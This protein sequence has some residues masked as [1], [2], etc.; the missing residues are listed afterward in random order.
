MGDIFEDI[1]HAVSDAWDD[2]GDIGQSVVTGGFSDI[3]KGDAPFHSVNQTLYDKGVIGSDA[4]GVADILTGAGSSFATG[5]LSDLASGIQGWH[6]TGDFWT[7]LDRT[8][9]PG[10]SIDYSFRSLGDMLPEEWKPYYGT[11]GTT[12]GGIVGSYIPVIG[13]A[14][15][16]AI[17]SGIGSKMAGGME[18]KDYKGDF[19]KAGTAYVAGKAAEFVASGFNAQGE[20]VNELGLTESEQAYMDSVSNQGILTQTTGAPVEYTPSGINYYP[21]GQAPA[22]TPAIGSEQLDSF[23]IYKGLVNTGDPSSLTN[24]TLNDA[25]ELVA[26]PTY[27]LDQNAQ[28]FKPSM[29]FI[30]TSAPLP[31][32]MPMEKTGILGKITAENLANQEPWYKYDNIKKVLDTLGK[33]Y[34][35]VAP[36]GGADTTGGISWMDTSAVPIEEQVSNIRQNM[37]GGMS[38]AAKAKILPEFEFGQPEQPSM[39][40]T[41]LRRMREEAL[42]S[43]TNK[44]LTAKEGG[45]QQWL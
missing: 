23:N 38:K 22:A 37:F 43:Q 34:G 20:P 32:L 2:I 27:F 11:A 42:E 4:L 16:A 7:G 29:E 33:A 40:D 12:I 13:T 14:A 39:M 17:G 41:L 36:G 9:D 30:D 31:Q 35:N 26:K 8:L 10:G 19:L 25:G 1:G 45:Q 18:N 15:G 24:Y 3:F 6:D 21:Q 5:G 28:P 44:I